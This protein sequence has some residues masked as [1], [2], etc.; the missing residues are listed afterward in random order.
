[1]RDH[2]TST[3]LTASR[4]EVKEAL[5]WLVELEESGDVMNAYCFQVST[6]PPLTHR[7]VM[8]LKNRGLVETSIYVEY[9]CGH[10]SNIQHVQVT[11][12]WATEEGI[13]YLK[14]LLK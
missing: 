1:M 11:D 8:A 14:E 5:N 9:D 3:L 4:T 7:V 10:P 6:E 2:K 13:E 12:V